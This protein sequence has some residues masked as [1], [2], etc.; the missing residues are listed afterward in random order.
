MRPDGSD[1]RALT[2][3]GGDVLQ[4]AWSPDGQRIAFSV[5]A[6]DSP[7]YELRTIGVD[8]KGIREVVPAANDTFGPSWSPNGE[9]I[10]FVEDGAVFAVQLEGGKVEELTSQE[11]NDLSP[12]W[13]PA[14]PPDG[15]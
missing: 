4:P 1:A 15:D 7:L 5:K 6:G 13:N 2:K 11:S 10:A 12:T 14:P 9:R 8:G 3:L